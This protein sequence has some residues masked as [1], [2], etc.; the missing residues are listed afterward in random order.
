MDAAR[1]HYERLGFRVVDVSG[2]NPYDLHCSRPDGAE[3][4]VEVKGTTGEGEEV[5]L[6]IG[7]VKHAR[8]H[9]GH[10]ALYVLHSIALAEEGDTHTATGGKPVII[11]PW[12]VDDGVLAATRYR[13][14]SGD[15]SSRSTR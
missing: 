6:T 11:E 14:S 1:W 2:N 12:D 9:I 7:E 10:I 3:L 5:E 15:G 4:R 8:G 13:W